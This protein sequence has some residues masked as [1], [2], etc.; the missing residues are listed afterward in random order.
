MS[1]T[2]TNQEARLP[3]KEYRV[4][5]ITAAI[6]RNEVEQ[7]GRKKTRHSIK[8]QK[9]YLNK[10]SEEFKSTEYYYPDEL[11]KLISAAQLAYD[12]INV[13]ESDDSDVGLPTV[14][15]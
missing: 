13:R 12:Y 3:I 11:P 6:W 15:M 7:D 5:P 14:A 2:Q 8:I 10:Q 1:Q 4:G 9:R